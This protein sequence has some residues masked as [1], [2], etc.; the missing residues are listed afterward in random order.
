[1]ERS[2]MRDPSRSCPDFE[3]NNSGH[4]AMRTS[5]SQGHQQLSDSSALS[6]PK[7]ANPARAGCT[8]FGF[9]HQPRTERIPMP[10]VASRTDS[11]FRTGVVRSFG[12]AGRTLILGPI[13]GLS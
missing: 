11:N 7:F 8:S 1:M 4:A 6:N 10:P 9:G 13:R 12:A 2:G 5:E 3:A